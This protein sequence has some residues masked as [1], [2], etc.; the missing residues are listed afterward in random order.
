MYIAGLNLSITESQA[1]NGLACASLAGSFY[2]AWPGA[3]FKT[4]AEEGGG[5]VT[6]RPSGKKGLYITVA[7]GLALFVPAAVFMTAIPTNKF[8]APEW[9]GQCALPEVSPPIHYAIRI[10]SSISLWVAGG[11]VF[12]SFKHLDTQW[13]YIGVRDTYGV[14]DTGPYKVVRHPMYSCALLT[15]LGTAGAFW[16]WIPIA[17]SG[18]LA[19][20][21]AYKIPLEENDILT[22]QYMGS[23]YT[24]YKEKVPSRVIPYIW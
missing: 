12:L 17:A 5:K 6:H 2:L 16:N 18:L 8:I 13:S 10:G 19:G 23:D 24:E 3:N 9:L 22:H 1:L 14:V 15:M 11:I 7:H 21:F 4:R 20:L